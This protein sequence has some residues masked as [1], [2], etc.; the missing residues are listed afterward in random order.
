MLSGYKVREVETQILPNTKLCLGPLSPRNKEAGQKRKKK[1]KKEDLNGR[2]RSGNI[3]DRF[4][5]KITGTY[6]PLSLKNRFHL[7]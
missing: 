4:Q 3:K 1:E 6:P 7:H 2:S 5:R